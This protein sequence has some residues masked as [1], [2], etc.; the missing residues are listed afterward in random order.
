MTIIDYENE[1]PDQQELKL[2]NIRISDE[3]VAG[4]QSWGSSKELA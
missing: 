2:E 4:R 1:N 3:F